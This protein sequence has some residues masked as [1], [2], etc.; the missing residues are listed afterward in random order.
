MAMP[1]RIPESARIP[2]LGA[3]GGGWVAGQLL[4][5]AAIAA[6]A[7]V[8]L[9]WPDELRWVAFGIGGGLIALGLLLVLVGGAQLGS[10]LTAFPAPRPGDRL[11]TGGLYRRARHP[12]YGGGIL[13]ALGWSIVFATV[14]GA[15][16][17]AALVLLFELKARRE[18]AWLR[19]HHP[20]YADYLE[21]TRRKF[22]PFVY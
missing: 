9:G 7:L 19:D 2:E 17:T 8:G 13:V 6:S 15:A 11:E 21:R 10:S 22:L 16:L 1:S 20:G 5:L 3:R 12:M 4:L 18:E 14:V